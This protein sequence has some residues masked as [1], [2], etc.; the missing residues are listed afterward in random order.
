MWLSTV[1]SDEELIQEGVIV[2]ME[3]SWIK[4]GSRQGG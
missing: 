4:E 1:K 3:S 2:V